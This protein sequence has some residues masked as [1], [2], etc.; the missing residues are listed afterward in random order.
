MEGVE[1]EDW[2]EQYQKSAEGKL[3]NY[4]QISDQ[5]YLSGYKAAEIMEVL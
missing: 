4:D 5:I 1:E 3:A 2:F